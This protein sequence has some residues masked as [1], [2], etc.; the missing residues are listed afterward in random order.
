MNAMAKETMTDLMALVLS[1]TETLNEIGKNSDL[2]EHPLSDT[3]KTAV[4]AA[5]EVLNADTVEMPGQYI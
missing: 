5:L 1:M 4:R 2:G 3:A